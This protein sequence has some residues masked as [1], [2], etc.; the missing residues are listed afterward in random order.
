MEWRLGRE[1]VFEGV[2]IGVWEEIEVRVG[3]EGQSF[4]GRGEYREVEGLGGE[5]YLK[6]QTL[7]V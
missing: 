6:M 3:K 2:S 5:S 4:G 1:W 7:I